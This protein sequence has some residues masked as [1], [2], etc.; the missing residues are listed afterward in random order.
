MVPEHDRYPDPGTLDPDCDPDCP[1]NL[2]DSSFGCAV[3]LQKVSSKSV[4]SFL[5]NIADRRT[6]G[7][8]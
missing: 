2:I 8:R 4:H 5:G 3:L 1:Q 7:H 6:D